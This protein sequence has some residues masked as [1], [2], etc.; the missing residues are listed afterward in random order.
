V[1][2]LGIRD[3][4]AL[5]AGGAQTCVR[6]RNDDAPWCFGNWGAHHRSGKP[7]GPHPS[8]VAARVSSLAGFATL[9]LGSP[10]QC[11]LDGFG[12]LHCEGWNDRGALGTN[13]LVATYYTPLGEGVTAVSAGSSNTCAVRAGRVLC[14]GANEDA[15]LG[16]GEWPRDDGEATVRFAVLP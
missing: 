13:E 8:L 7:T 4:T 12:G 6:R 3:A 14:W 10:Q 5:W 16:L 2:V 11:V 1:P 15:V 9:A